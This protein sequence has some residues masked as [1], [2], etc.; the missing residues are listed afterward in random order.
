MGDIG[1]LLILGIGVFGG[2][3]G[4]TFF[5]KLKFPP[6]AGYIT[7]GLVIGQSGFELISKQNISQ[8][9]SL[10]DFALG[11]I[12]FLVGAELKIPTFQKYGKQLTSILFGE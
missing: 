11:V 5:Q 12:G 3:L 7:I 1:V 2:I 9:S 8:F 4:A 6:V 10:N